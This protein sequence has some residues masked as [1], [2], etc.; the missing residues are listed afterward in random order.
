[1]FSP[2]VPYL[3]AF[4]IKPP[5][6]FELAA[7]L[8]LV[9]GGDPYLLA[10][11]S[12]LAATGSVVLTVALIGML[13][14]E[15]TG[16]SYAAYVAGTVPLTYPPYYQMAAAGLR[17][18]H[19]A[20]VFGL[21]GVFLI[22]RRRWFLGGIATAFA[23]AS[24]QLAIIF[25]IA[26]VLSA[27]RNGD[28]RAK[29]R[30]VV[31]MGIAVIIVC[32]P[33]VLAGRSALTS[34]VLQSILPVIHSPSVERISLL[35]RLAKFVRFYRVAALFIVAG[36]VGAATFR[37][38]DRAAWVPLVAGWFSLGLLAFDFGGLADTF[39]F[40]VTASVGAGFLAFALPSHVDGYKAIFT[41][42]IVLG[43]VGVMFAFFGNII[44]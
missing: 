22:L 10:L 11:I 30:T 2:R 15:H 32:A 21:L 23:A 26:A 36:I 9:S 41:P 43:V 38:F 4:D 3:H 5:G 42:L 27:T 25:P 29:Y 34:M 6:I 1:M 13:V 7:L 39:L 12:I 33:F 14:Y 35:G 24:W 20:P 16:S 18:K 31:G 44:Q 40:L 17:P 8:S 28:S 37:D 19:F